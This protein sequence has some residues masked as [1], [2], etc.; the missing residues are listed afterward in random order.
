MRYA[1]TLLLAIAAVL[2]LLS[3]LALFSASASVT[4]LADLGEKAGLETLLGEPLLPETSVVFLTLADLL[5]DV[6]TALLALAALYALLSLVTL[7]GAYFAYREDKPGAIGAGGGS[8]LLLALITF[9]MAGPTPLLAAGLIGGLVA[10]AYAAKLSRAPQAPANDDIPL[11]DISELDALDPSLGLDS[12]PGLGPSQEPVESPQ[13]SSDPDFFGGERDQF[14]D[15]LDK[16]KDDQTDRILTLLG[17]GGV[18]IAV[19]LGLLRF[20]E[21]I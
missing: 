1:V 10:L 21:L 9:T 14:S 15:S 18:G 12:E 13:Q 3:A 2:D 19:L 7:T 4:E 17:G 5:V 16:R 8:A 20:L 6:G 11:G